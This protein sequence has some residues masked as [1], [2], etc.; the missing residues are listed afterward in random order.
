MTQYNHD[1]EVILE[2]EE[3]ADCGC[4]QEEGEMESTNPDGNYVCDGCSEDYTHCD[5]CG[6]HLPF[7]DTRYS[8]LHS[9][10]Y[11]EN[12]YYDIITHC[13]D[14]DCEIDSDEAQYSETSGDYYCYDCFP[15]ER[16]VWEVYSNNFIRDNSD[17]VNPATDNYKRD[18]FNLIKS[19]R[20]VGIEIETNYEDEQYNSDIRDYLHRRINESRELEVDL[21]LTPRRQD[22]VYDGSVTD[23]EHRYGNEIVMQPRRGDLIVQDVDTITSSLKRIEAYPSVRCGLH[24]HIDARDYDWLHFSVLTLM[25]KLIEPHVYTWVPPSRLS[26][27]WSRKVSQ[28]VKD[29]AY[30]ADRDEFI[31]VYYDNGGFSNDKYNDKRY[32]GL[33]LHCH[34]QAN[35]GIEIRYHGG[36]LN[37]EKIKHWT[38]FWTNVVDTCY[39]IAEEIKSGQLSSYNNFKSNEI[40]KSLVPLK[41]DKLRKL[42]LR[43]NRYH[44]KDGESTDIAQ[45]K[46]DS[47]MLR[48]Y[49]KLPK[50]KKPYLVEPMLRYLRSREDRT[51]MSIENIFD[52]F[53]IPD[54]TREF[55]KDRT[56]TIRRRDENHI[57]SCF[58]GMQSV[59]EF[60][61]VT[62]KFHY[63]DNMHNQFPLI[64]D[65]RLSEYC[66]TYEFGNTHD[67]FHFSNNLTQSDYSRFI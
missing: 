11:C 58:G 4:E 38:I 53:R 48:R 20:Y 46:K 66:P 67:L 39:E 61:R 23:S 5:N 25:T 60:D 37:T 30:I 49:L 44:M 10:Y 18:T 36:T 35:Q 43:Y 6:E 8:E 14:C 16:P 54:E 63:V 1:E 3:C 50:H 31:D 62:H 33:N 51:F 64:S 27:N 29:F 28:S 45:Y 22:V 12:C 40:Y 24:L 13:A 17:F 59:V 56:K 41:N 34:F 21:Q 15:D 47:E 9:E 32:H 7:D 2:M 57:T 52:T 65:T 19:R 55:F 26:G 42:E